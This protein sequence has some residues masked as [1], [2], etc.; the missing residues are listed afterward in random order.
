MRAD[1]KNGDGGT[2]GGGDSPL[3]LAAAEKRDSPLALAAAAVAK[4]LH[5]VDVDDQDLASAERVAIALGRD[6]EALRLKAEGRARRGG[7]CA[8]EPQAKKNRVY[9]YGLYRYDLYSY[10]LCEGAW[11]EEGQGI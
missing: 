9:S 3:A 5:S 2:D 4:T 7:F 11:S 8:K 1:G 6:V 10:G